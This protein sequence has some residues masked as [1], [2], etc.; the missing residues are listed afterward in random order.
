MTAIMAHPH[1]DAI[2]RDVG[3]PKESSLLRSVVS[4][5][6][7]GKVFKH[8]HRFHRPCGQ[9]GSASNAEHCLLSALYHWG[10]NR[11]GFIFKFAHPSGI[12][13]LARH[14]D[15]YA[16][17]VLGP[18]YM[19]SWPHYVYAL[20][21]WFWRKES[22]DPV[23]KDMLLVDCQAATESAGSPRAH[24]VALRYGRQTE[25]TQGSR[26][27]GSKAQ[28]LSSRFEES[29]HIREVTPSPPE[30]LAS[31]TAPVRRRG[32]YCAK[33]TRPSNPEGA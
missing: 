14:M 3:F 17:I 15:G 31:R 33:R 16:E 11:F 25:D 24:E 2:R 10:Q 32:G 29:R 19:L 22:A 5:L 9:N 8:H 21:F 23:S 27:P 28:R 20:S 1:P 26:D 12:A 4:L 13:S 18:I 7:S 6:G 30:E